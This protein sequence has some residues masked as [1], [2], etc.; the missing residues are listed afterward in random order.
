MSDYIINTNITINEL[1][2]NLKNSLYKQKYNN[3]DI[4]KFIMKNIKVI[5]T[6]DGIPHYILCL[7]N[8]FFYVTMSNSFY[9]D[10]YIT[11]IVKITNYHFLE[12]IPVY[13]IELDNISLGK[14]T[15][16]ELETVNI[17]KD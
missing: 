15:K 11:D 14:F 4:N 10:D 12:N 13:N 5:R 2:N 3:N 8:E 6:L 9:I 1:V 17:L 16:S 7:N